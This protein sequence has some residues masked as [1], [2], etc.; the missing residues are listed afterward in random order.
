[1]RGSLHIPSE[2]NLSHKSGERALR[3]GTESSLHFTQY[4]NGPLQCE[5]KIDNTVSFY[6]NTSF[7]VKVETY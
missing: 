5:Y 4:R 2:W 6:G 3:L 1:M 7:V